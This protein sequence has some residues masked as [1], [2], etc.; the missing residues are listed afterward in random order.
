M[1]LTLSVIEAERNTTLVLRH[2]SQTPPKS[3]RVPARN[4]SRKPLHWDVTFT[5]D[6]KPPFDISSKLIFNEYRTLPSSL[7]KI[8]ACSKLNPGVFIMNRPQNAPAR[9]TGASA[10]QAM[11]INPSPP[12]VAD[13][14]QINPFVCLY[15]RI[16]VLLPSLRTTRSSHLEVLEQTPCA[17]R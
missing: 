9:P 1:S 3:P 4:G 14:I 17:S 13:P 2:L 6:P 5:L 12:H 16:P 10:A 8:R 11:G 7:I 15:S